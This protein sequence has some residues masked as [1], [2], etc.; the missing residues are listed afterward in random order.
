MFMDV[1]MC[2]C[3]VCMKEKANKVKKSGIRPPNLIS[4]A[5]LPDVLQ[6][7]TIPRFFISRCSVTYCTVPVVNV[8]CRHCDMQLL[9]GVKM[10]AAQGGGWSIQVSIY[11]CCESGSGIRCFLTPGSGVRV[12]SLDPG[13]GMEQNPGPGSG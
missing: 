8:V 13:P 9:E 2:E 11:Q 6:C 3:I 1:R 12:P 10:L 4:L 7:C 5:P